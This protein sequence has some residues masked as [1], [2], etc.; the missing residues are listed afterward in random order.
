MPWWL[1]LGV[2]A[3]GVAAVL[4][5]GLWMFQRRLIY[6][7]DQSA[8][9]S[10]SQYL[11]GG[12]DVVLRTDDGMELAAW[13]VPARHDCRRTVLIAPGNAGNRADR[14]PL[15]RALADHGLGVL[16]LDYRGYGGNPGRPDEP[17]LRADAQAAHHFLTHE[18]VVPSGSLIYYGESLGAAVMTDLAAARPPAAL[19]LRSP[20]TDLAAAAAAAFPV[21][22]VR[23]MLWDKWS[24]VERLSR[25]A[26]PTTVIYGT[27]DTVIPPDLSLAVARAA[28]GP[29]TVI[30]VPGA[31]HNDQ[32]LLDGQPVVDAVLAAAELAGC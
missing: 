12:Q 27:A 11:A 19:V 30:A 3:M 8:P 31:N 14:A 32:V 15:G 24:V 18:Q 2:I 20:F 23:Q 7:P 9:G 1:R 29:S 26:V 21:L 10:A 6:Q 28:P 5:A 17:G 4:V 16:M 22:P 13:Y 25:T